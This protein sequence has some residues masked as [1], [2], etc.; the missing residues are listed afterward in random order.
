LLR[1]KENIK[2]IFHQKRILIKY[3]YFRRSFSSSYT[4]IFFCQ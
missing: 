2:I 3:D 1:I 4:R